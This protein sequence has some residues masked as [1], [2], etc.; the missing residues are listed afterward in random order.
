AGEDGGALWLWDLPSGSSR[1]LK[2]SPPRY[3]RALGFSP[4]GRTLA[5]AVATPEEILLWDVSSARLRGRLMSP[6]VVSSLLF[7]QDCKSLAVLCTHTGQWDLPFVSFDVMPTTGSFP[8]ASPEE[9]KLIA[10]EFAD[11][12]LQL[13]ADML[14]EMQPNPVA[15]LDGLKESWVRRPPRGVAQNRNKSMVVVGFG[16]GTFAVYRESYSLRLMVAR[17]HPHGTAIVQ[18][19]PLNAFG[20]PRP[21]EREQIER[22]TGHLVGTSPAQRRE[23]D[24][25]VRQR[26]FEPVAFSPDGRNL[27]IW[28]EEGDRLRVV[29]LTTGRDRLTF[30][31]GP[32]NDL[33]SM[34]FTPDGASL[35]FGAMDHK[36]RLWHLNTPPNPQVLRGHSPKEVWSVAFSPDGR[37]LASGGDDH[38]VRLRDLQTGRETKVLRSHDA[39]V[40]SVAFAPDGQTLA[41]GSFDLKKPLILWDMTTG[42]PKFLLEGH[43]NRVRGVAFSPDGR[44][45]ASGSEDY[46]TMIWD[47]VKGV[48]TKTIPHRHHTAYCTA[49]SPDGRTVASGAGADSI[50]LIDTVTGLIRLITTDPQVSSLTFSP[51]G[52]HLTPGHLDG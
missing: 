13:L 18:F 3:T 42:L 20:E 28:H 30:D 5:W 48:R 39:L 4:D 43:A 27:A 40:T 44:T 41:S 23:S 38:Q 33:R 14:D 24:M 34:V 46:T 2:G 22:L 51:D 7:S 35:A 37:T 45:L 31:L 26:F 21:R 9:S 52:S 25:I 36:V 19:D 17:I 16:D 32:L 49:F 8:Y 29:D 47:T 10:T 11:D 6:W 15:S 50:V 1:R 12:R